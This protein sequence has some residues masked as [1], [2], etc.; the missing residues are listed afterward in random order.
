MTI[1]FACEHDIPD[2][3]RIYNQAI[4]AGNATADLEE[5]D[6]VNRLEWF[7]SHHPD[8][9]PLYI[10]EEDKRAIGWGSLSPY[11]KG[12]AALKGTAEISYYVDYDHHGKGYGR[13]LI[14]HMLGDCNRLGINNLIAFLLEINTISIRI[15][16]KFGFERWGCLPGIAELREGE[17]SHLIYGKNLRKSTATK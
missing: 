8:R 12:R 9:F 10:I 2:I 4:E 3:S 11:R 16:E 15:L 13:L 6:A 5:P 14:S 7:R 1:R 17:C